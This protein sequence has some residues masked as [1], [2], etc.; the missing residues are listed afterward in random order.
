MASSLVGRGRSTS[1]ST[2][3]STAS[4]RHSTSMP[5]LD[6]MNLRSAQK[7]R[8]L[9]VAKRIVLVRKKSEEEKNRVWDK[10]KELSRLLVEKMEV[11][12]LVKEIARKRYRAKTDED[13]L[14][15]AVRDFENLELGKLIKMY[16]G[17]SP[18]GF[19]LLI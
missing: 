2:S 14:T 11:P 17:R 13:W 1:R 6:L 12:E 8:S 3:F 18:G 10:V 7:S 4:S 19:T 15:R 5:L 16:H 9:D